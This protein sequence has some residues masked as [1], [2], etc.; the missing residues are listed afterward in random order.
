M[1]TSLFRTQ[2]Q[3]PAVIGQSSPLDICHHKFQLSC[4]LFWGMV[5]P[6]FVLK[7]MRTPDS[8]LGRD[9]AGGG[10]RRAASLL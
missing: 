10:L 4:C 3:D 6:D 7:G 9:C 5:N 1:Y 2:L 8:T